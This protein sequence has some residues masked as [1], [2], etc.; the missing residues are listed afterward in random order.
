M[1]QANLYVEVDEASGIIEIS[2]DK[3]GMRNG[4][5]AWYDLS[6]RRLIGVPAQRGIYIHE[7]RKVVIK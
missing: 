3:S 4:D 7:G 1:I 5:D 2:N 6:G